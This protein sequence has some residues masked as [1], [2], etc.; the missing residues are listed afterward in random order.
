VQL[1]AL[2]RAH[3]FMKVER[4]PELWE[5]DAEDVTLIP[6]LGE[7]I[8]AALSHGVPLESLTLNA[9]NVV[10]EPDDDGDD[11]FYPRPGEYVALTV[12][13]EVDIGPDATWNPESSSVAG[14]LGRLGDRLA[15]AGAR[16]AYIRRI[17][18]DGSITVYFGR[19]QGNDIQN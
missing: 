1:D 15:T 8:A 13:G 11:D 5:A 6:L 4:P 17:P 18:P 9:S 2:L 16:F 12:S 19:L 10:M 7:M 14:L 3:S